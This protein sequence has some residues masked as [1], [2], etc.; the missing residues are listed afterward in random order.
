MTQERIQEDR[1]MAMSGA[2]VTRGAA[3]EIR[4]GVFRPDWS[5]VTAPATA[6]AINGRA[7]ARAAVLDRW[8]HALEDAE[9]LVWRTTL[10]L[11]ADRGRPPGAEEI[12]AETWIA[13]DQVEALLRR[14]QSHDLIGLDPDTG[15]IRHAYPF[16]EAATGHRVEL[17]GRSLNALCAM[18]ALGVGAMYRRDV[19]IESPCRLCGAAV[20]VA[21][22]DEGRA[23]RDV[24]PV[25]AVVWYDFAFSGSAAA[26]SC[27]AIAFFCSDNHLRDWLEAQKRRREGVRLTMNEALEMGRAIFGPVLVEA[28]I[29]G[30]AQ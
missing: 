2:S 21:T 25:R 4:P 15:A 10:R 12:A 11:Y 24:A 19:T 7:A 14:L 17:G 27:T 16:T 28:R 3:V 9:D 26:S 20:H 6:E 13:P 18:D 30:G 23:L 1:V 22:A 29:P 8:S 5:V